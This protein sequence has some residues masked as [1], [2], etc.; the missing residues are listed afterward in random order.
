[1]LGID[2]DAIA[3]WV[4]GEGFQRQP[5]TPC[6]QNRLAD[7]VAWLTRDVEDKGALVRWA[8]SQTLSVGC[9][10]TAL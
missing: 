1:M 3:T 4:E 6:S 10:L 8:L 5:A 9:S 7:T 2:A